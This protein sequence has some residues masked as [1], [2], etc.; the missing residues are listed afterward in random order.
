MAA[1]IESIAPTMK[2]LKSAYG[3]SPG[4]FFGTVAPRRQAS[5]ATTGEYEGNS[6]SRAPTATDETSASKTVPETIIENGRDNDQLERVVEQA[7]SNLLN[8]NRSLRF[9]INENSDD[10]QIQIV[11]SERDKVIRS[12]PSDEMLRLASRMRELSGVGAMVDQSR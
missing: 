9:R 2:V 8:E 4:A 7:N 6:A 5:A 3:A 11:D 10:V 1:G 12:I